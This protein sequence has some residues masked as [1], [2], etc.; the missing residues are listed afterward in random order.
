MDVRSDSLAERRDKIPLR[1]SWKIRCK[2]ARLMLLRRIFM[3]E[4]RNLLPVKQLLT[5]LPVS[6]LL[7][8]EPIG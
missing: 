4:E 8:L 3:A 1:R 7:D 2:W 5:L 6:I